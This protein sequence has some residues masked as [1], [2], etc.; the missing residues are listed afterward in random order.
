MCIREQLPYPPE[1]KSTDVLRKPRAGRKSARSC[2]TLVGME[3]SVTDKLGLAGGV[4]AGKLMK[5]LLKHFIETTS[6]QS[7]HT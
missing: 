7:P 1:A 5:G 2:N 6:R 3:E 4:V